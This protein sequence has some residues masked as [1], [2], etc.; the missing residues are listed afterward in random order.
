[1]VKIKGEEFVKKLKAQEVVLQSVSGRAMDDLVVSGEVPISPTMFRDHANEV[2]S[3]GAPVEWTPM[4]LVP[5]NTGGVAIVA[6]AARPHGA[7]LMADFLLSS[8]GAKILSDLEYGSPLK[9]VSYKLWYPEAGMTTAQYE[10]TMERWQ[11][12][13]QEIGRR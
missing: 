12:L 1:M 10:K 13:L 4:D 5:T 9:P 3:K 11:K 7:V 2:K 8:E 6:Q